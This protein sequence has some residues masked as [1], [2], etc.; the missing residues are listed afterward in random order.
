MRRRIPLLLCSCVLLILCLLVLS[1]MEFRSTAP[2]PVP[3]VSGGYYADAFT[4][5]LSAPDNGSIYYTTDGSV[6]SEQSTRYENG[7]PLKNR[8]SEPNLYNAIQNVTTEWQNYTPDSTPVEKGT[9]IRA[10]FINKWGISSDI[11]TQTYFV[12]LESPKQ[13]YTLS[14]IFNDE[15][16][17]GTQGIYVTGPEYDA[18]YLNTDHSTEAPLANFQLDQEVIVTAELLD[19]SGDVLNQ[20]VGLR[21]QGAS[22]RTAV[23]KR[24]TL[25]SRQEYSGIDVFDAPLYEGI[26]THSVMLKSSLPDAIVAD[27][28]SDRAAAVQKSIPVRVFLNGEYWYDSYMLE[29]Y[30]THYFRQN[31]NISHRILVKNGMVDSDCYSDEEQYVYE[32][33]M[34]WVSE[35][36]FSIDANWESF[37][38]QTDVQSYIDFIVTNYY[39]CNTDFGD[40]HNYVVWHA[41][42]QGERQTDATRWKWCLFDID[43]VEWFDGFSLAGTPAAVNTFSQE[44]NLGIHDGTLFRA[45]RSSPTFCQQFVLSFMDM[46]NNNFSIHRVEGILQKY[47][48]GLD[49]LDGF[50]QKRPAYAAAH[51]AEEFRLTGSLEIVRIGTASPEMG[52]VVV[53]TSTIDLSSGN[54]SG[55]YFTDYPITVTAIAGDGYEFIGWKGEVN[56][57]DPTVTLHMDGGVSLEAVFAE[58]K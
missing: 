48:Y 54:W 13:G 12:G 44:E 16:L 53:N 43:C 4:L 19:N 21:I 23:K 40:R 38:E 57:A 2:T 1:W 17:F 18:W 42:S 45:L 56:T 47:G 9:V 26:T 33:Y 46:L 58:I 24:F 14:L 36:D 27:L 25:V 31:Y 35:T 7:I 41:P 39:L 22:A 55:Q 49:W 34:K 3:S 10:V 50:F 29:R 30:D 20:P 5:H 11:M 28:V 8:S 32:T 52:T 37:R 51:L 6:P 15:D